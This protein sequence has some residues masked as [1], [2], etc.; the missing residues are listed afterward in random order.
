ML[1]IATVMVLA[2]EAPTAA[3]EKYFLGGKVRPVTTEN[4]QNTVAGS[5]ETLESGITESVKS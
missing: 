4:P 3:L 1:G 5:V 2:F